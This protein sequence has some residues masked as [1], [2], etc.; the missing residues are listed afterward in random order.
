[1]R[2]LKPVETDE[3]QLEVVEC[4]CGYH[5]G[6]DFTFFDQVKDHWM[7]CPSC[8]KLIDSA[9]VFP[10]DSG[11]QPIP[12]ISAPLSISDVV[13]QV[14]GVGF[15]QGIVPCDFIDL[16]KNHADDME[17]YLSERLIGNE[18]LDGVEYW[19]VG[20]QPTDGLYL[21]VGGNVDEWVAGMP[22]CQFCKALAAPDEW[23]LHQDG[24][25]CESCWDER[26]RSSE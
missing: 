7:V 12:M 10:D 21:Y 25:V 16:L 5:L 20:G 2:R 9:V 24:V 13:R 15:V 26:L 1:M 22:K 4:D 23:H 3:V 11:R 18:L 19:I 17:S 14:M 6:L 8:G